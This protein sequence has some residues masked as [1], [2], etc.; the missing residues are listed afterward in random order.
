MPWVTP[1]AVV[2]T[3]EQLRACARTEQ[4]AFFEL[5]EDHRPESDPT[6]AGR[7][8]ERSMLTRLGGEI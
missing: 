7:Y 8:R 4:R 2:V 1:R 5:K 3:L 6:A